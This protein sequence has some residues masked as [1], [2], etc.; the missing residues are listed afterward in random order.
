[1]SSVGIRE[2]VNAL[3]RENHLAG[4]GDFHLFQSLGNSRREKDYAIRNVGDL[5]MEVA[6]SKA[7]S[8]KYKNAMGNY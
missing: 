5:S 6:T 1:M 2:M 3:F 7:E 8:A 4:V